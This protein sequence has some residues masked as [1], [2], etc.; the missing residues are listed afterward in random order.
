MIAKVLPVVRATNPDR[1]VVIGPV[2]WNNLDELP[3]LVLPRADRNIIVTFHSYEPFG[4]THQGAPWVEGM[5][6]VHGVA[7]TGD[8]ERRIASDYDKVAA[9]SKAEDRP[10]LMGEFGAY[11]RS[12]TPMEARARY[13]ATVRRKP[14]SVASPG[15][16]GSSTAI[17]CC[18]TWT[19]TS[20]SSRSAR[21]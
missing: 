11:D 3:N 9:W 14:R 4:F 12:G 19:R 15:L 13:T 20:G 7:F 16:I 6:D 10:I 5:K 17:S 1:T 2:R 21:R 18:G 8:D